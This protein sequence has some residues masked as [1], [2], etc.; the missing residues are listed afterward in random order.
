ME[1]DLDSDSG[2][3]SPL[4]RK[5]QVCSATQ[6]DSI[7]P[8]VMSSSSI[9]SDDP[10]IVH[11]ATVPQQKFSY[12]FIAQ[13]EPSPQPVLSVDN[14][15]KQDNYEEKRQ[16]QV[17]RNNSNQERSNFN[18]KDNR[19]RDYKS[20]SR[21]TYDPNSQHINKNIGN[22]FDGGGKLQGD[23]QSKGHQGK[24]PGQK[25][26]NDLEENT[27]GGYSRSARFEE[28]DYGFSRTK[29]LNTEKQGERKNL[30]ESKSVKSFKNGKLLQSDNNF[31]NQ[32]NEVLN[33]EKEDDDGEAGK[34]KRRRRR[35]RKRKNKDGEPDSQEEGKP[36]QEEGK[37]DQEEVEL[38]FEDVE[39][40]PDLSSAKV[41]DNMAT[42][43]SYSAILQQTVSHYLT[44]FLRKFGVG[45]GLW[46]LMPLSPIFQL[47][48]GGQFY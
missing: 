9:K 25:H 16:K 22:Q 46:H 11:A 36:D 5:N 19:S 18:R 26:F 41:S 2:Y 8:W 3:S 24:R 15:K 12:A 42:G 29:N 17:D 10:S 14:Q 38:H 34:K 23:I 1:L 13:K 40:F 45:L 28:N 4:H 20:T 27:K 31:E 47:Y 43:I 32:R 35:R 21:N 44:C 30:Q 39:E 33:D 6:S 48:C 7:T 37:P